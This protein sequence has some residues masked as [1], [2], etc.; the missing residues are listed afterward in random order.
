[1]RILYIIADAT[2]SALTGLMILSMIRYYTETDM[3]LIDYAFTGVMW[4]AAVKWNIRREE[5]KRTAAFDKAAD[6]LKD[7][8]AK[9]GR[10][11]VLPDGF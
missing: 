4:A 10:T 6:A 3:N 1:M 8:L 2:M 9:P 11:T 7:A 5:R